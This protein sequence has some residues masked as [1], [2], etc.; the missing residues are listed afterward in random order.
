MADKPICA[1]QD[2]NKP[3]K[4]RGWCVAHYK[5]FLRHG[6]PLAGGI[7]K[8]EARRFLDE[9]AI[10][11]A[12]ADC[13]I[14]PYGKTAAGYGMVMVEGRA[15]YTHVFVCE[16]VHGA[17][18]KG[19]Y[20]AAHK[21]GNPACCN[22]KHLRWA[23]PHENALDKRGHGTMPRGERHHWAKLSDEEV[24]AIIDLKGRQNRSAV[25]K[26]FGVDPKYVDAVWAGR[27]RAHQTRPAEHFRRS[28][29]PIRLLTQ[30]R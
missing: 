28:T 10:P 24:D 29:L 18:P 14:W 22:P 5:R 23:T 8:R 19:R 25:A 4:T 20:E 13:L 6:D 11:Y 3:V 26:Q 15:I 30:P 7:P 1:I 2:C 17:R 9:C 12:G 21:C 27:L 16:A